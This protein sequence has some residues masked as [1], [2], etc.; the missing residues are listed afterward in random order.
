M[1]RNRTLRARNAG[2]EYLN[3]EFGWDPLISDIRSFADTI[4]K[5]DEILRQYERDKG[6]LV[7]RRRNLPSVRTESTTLLSANK[8]PTATL[9]STT[10]PGSFP[11]TPGVWSVRDVRYVETWFSG[12]F[13]Y[14]LP[15][16]ST[17]LGG[18]SSLASQADRL[19]GLSLT[20]D[21]LWELTPWSWAIDW[22]SNTGDVLSNLSDV[23]TQGLVLHYGYIME[24]TVHKRIYSL[25]GVQLNGQPFSTPDV[26]LVSETKKRL[27]A[28]PF[29]FGVSWDGLSPFQLAIAAALGISRS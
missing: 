27:K 10:G 21:V 29:G 28:S 12:A 19:F 11:F 7:R 22:F 3:K 18:I 6:N 8:V 2:G 1:W 17:G 24:H 9:F 23:M 20:P 5:S 25:R 26:T 4:R 16:N 15:L 14:G 13:S